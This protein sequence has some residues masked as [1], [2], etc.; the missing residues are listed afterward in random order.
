MSL[1]NDQYNNLPWTEKYRPPDVEDLILNDFF[2]SM[3]EQFIKHKNIPNLILTGPS[4]IGKTSTIKCLATKLYGKYKKDM[5][6]ELNASD[7]RGMKSMQE[8]IILFCKSSHCIKKT[9]KDKYANFKLIILDEADNMVDRAQP[10]INSIM[11]QYKDTV[12]FAFT[13]NMSNN[14]IEAIQSRCRI[15]RYTRL[16]NK[17][18]VKKLKFIAKSENIK[19][20][21]DALSRISEISHGDM[22]N[23]INLMQLVF[24]NK[25]KIKIKY[26]D[27]FCDL[28]QHVTIL[29]LFNFI[30]NDKLDKAFEILHS[31]KKMGFSGSDITLGMI[32]S[33]KSNVCN[34]I[35]DENKI[36][37][38]NQICF[39]SYNISKGTDTILQLYGCLIDLK[40]ACTNS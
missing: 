27:E 23:A 24:N 10:Q 1:E 40:N 28:P 2:Q 18:I 11:E 35:S 9:D 33:L 22:R 37:L 36:K 4:G 3:I 19:Y 29:K 20:K 12:R 25:E 6:L 34:E 16:D 13:C 17:F 38:M 21:K 30:L 32:Y 15:L 14:I 26:V 5:V 7:D 31:L 39:A 8:S